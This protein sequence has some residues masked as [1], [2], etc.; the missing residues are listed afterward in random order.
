MPRLQLSNL[1]MNNQTRVV[2]LLNPIANQDA[3]TKA[4]VD[5]A[6]E[7][8]GWKDSV[9]AATQG[10]IN[11][12]NPGAFI[13][14]VAIAVGGRVLV[15]A[16][17]AAAENGIYI[18]NTSTSPM[19]RA[20]DANTWLEL[21]Q[22][23]CAVERGTSAGVSYRQTQVDG[24][25]GTSAINWTVFGQ[26][27][28]AASTTTAGAIQIALQSEVDA[29]TNTVKAITPATLAASV[30]AKRKF[31]STFG[32]GSATLYTLTH[33]FGT[34]DV[35]VTVYRNSAPFD[36]VGVDVERDTVNSCV[37]RFATAP[38]ANAYR[39]VVIG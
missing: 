13:D 2:N 9:Y 32:D 31:S 35:E 34:R 22:A 14:G 10:N 1:D 39:I 33:N 11:L 24:A 38:A 6:V 29:G 30:W 3:A 5:S 4:Y 23:V 12:A 36:D 20:P 25:L 18:F 8:L 27:T 37:V 15:Q 16:Q 26:A 28:P 19:T 7:G 21:E 17:T